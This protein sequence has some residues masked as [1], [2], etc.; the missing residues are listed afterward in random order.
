MKAIQLYMQQ[1]KQSGQ[2]GDMNVLLQ[3]VG[4]F[5]KEMNF[6]PSPQVIN[7]RKKEAE[8]APGAV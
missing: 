7:Q 8:N 3:M 2:P 5:Q 1:I 4:Q 6:P